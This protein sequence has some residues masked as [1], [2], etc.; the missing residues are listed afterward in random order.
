MVGFRVCL[1]VRAGF[2]G[3]L[4]GSVL[5]CCYIYIYIYMGGEELIEYRCQLDPFARPV[6][7]RFSR[8]ERLE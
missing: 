7:A 8:F 1:V 5:F 2:P 6:S 3:W 4:R